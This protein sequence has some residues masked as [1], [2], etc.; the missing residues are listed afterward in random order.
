MLEMLVVYLSGLSTS[1]SAALLA[2]IEISFV[3]VLCKICL[4]IELFKNQSWAFYFCENGPPNQ[5][6]FPSGSVVFRASL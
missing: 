4:Q 2:N 1:C 5:V 6:G 3:L